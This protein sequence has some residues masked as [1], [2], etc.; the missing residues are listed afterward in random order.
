MKLLIIFILF[1]SC[2][3]EQ[4]GPIGSHHYKFTYRLTSD[5]KTVSSALKAP[6]FKIILNDGD[7]CKLEIKNKEQKVNTKSSQITE[8]A[9]IVLLCKKESMSSYVKTASNKLILCGGENLQSDSKALLT[10]GGG[11]Y[12][13][14]IF[15]KDRP[16][17]AFK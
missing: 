5:E 13:I 15:Y 4:K 2:V 7:E 17:C 14:E 11:G 3:K 8:S 6:E 12:L 10:S 1:Y 16:Y 9:D